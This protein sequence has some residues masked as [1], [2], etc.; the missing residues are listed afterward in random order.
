MLPYHEKVIADRGYKG[1][2]FCMTSDDSLN[3]EHKK[4][5]AKARARHETINQRLKKWGYEITMAT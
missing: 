1:N 3:E 5:M 4:F 2:P